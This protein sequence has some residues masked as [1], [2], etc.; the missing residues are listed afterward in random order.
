MLN[1][2][3]VASDY[4][5]FLV[6]VADMFEAMASLLPPYHQI[7]AICKRRMVSPQ[8]DVEDERLKTLMSYVYLDILK[9]L[10]DTYRI[11]FRRSQGTLQ[12]RGALH[13]SIMHELWW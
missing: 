11:F 4:A 2:L 9:L 12:A 13:S 5:L 6:K 1:T 10:L 7:Y 3:Q 8:V